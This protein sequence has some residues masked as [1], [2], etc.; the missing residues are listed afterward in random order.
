MRVTEAPPLSVYLH[1][2]WCLA[3]CPYC[4]FNSHRVPEQPEQA[5]LSYVEA[6]ERDI[7]AQAPLVSG[8]AVTTVFLGGGTPSLFSPYEIG[9]VLHTCSQHL[10]IEPDA[11]VTMEVN[12][13]ALERGSF[14]G[15]RAA[16][17][18]RVSIGGQSFDAGQLRRLG[19]L[20]DPEAIRRAV[21][22]ARAAG[23]ERINVDV[24]YGLPGQ[25]EAGAVADAR[26]AVALD[27]S[28]VSH[29]QLT[30]EPNTVFHANP[31]ELP[32]EDAIADMM[33]ATEQ[34]FEDAGLARY[35]VSALAAEG[36]ACRHNLNYWQFG[37]YLGVGAGAHGKLTRNGAVARLL[38]PANPRGYMQAVTAGADPV[39]AAVAPSDLPFEYMLNALRLVD[40]FSLADYEARTG[41]SR[42][43]VTE[44]L[45][46]AAERGLMVQ[47]DDQK[48]RPTALGRRFLNDL[49]AMFLS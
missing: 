11:E 31:P 33:A 2:P 23:F 5:R 15:Y 21:S 39:V 25:D 26:A 29:Y 34:V 28:H 6:L 42:E 47:S 7:A 41:L 8:R 4:D 37:D 36:E 13:G 22:D 46:A 1:L 35:E 3:K 44:T 48:W 19:R 14:E 9:R 32:G 18:N 40:G 17:V 30:L 43:G 16:G 10:S 24:M 38:R 49:Q 27:L 20:H 12:P 45:E